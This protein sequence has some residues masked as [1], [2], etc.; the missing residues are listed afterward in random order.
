MSNMRNKSIRPAPSEIEYKGM[1]FLIT[2]RPTENTLAA[3]VEELKRHNARSVVRVCEPTYKTD[4]LEQEGI[5]VTDLVY[6]DGTFPPT[7]VVDDWLDLLRKRF[8]ADPTAC[9]AVHCVAGLGRAP[10]LVALA[11]MELG[12]KYEDAVELI[13]QKR[14]GAIN[15]KQL[16]YLEKYRP[17]SRLKLK[18]GHKAGCCIQ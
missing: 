16:Q 5:S 7:A 4:L 9:V 8:R 11:L 10:V 1:R 17:R 6:D 14:R 13:R 15:A 12:L 18:N 2:D 3:Y